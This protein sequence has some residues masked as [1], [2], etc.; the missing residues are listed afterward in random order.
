ML[1]PDQSGSRIRRRSHD[2]HGRHLQAGC[3]WRGNPGHS[4]ELEQ[5][6]HHIKPGGHGS[7][8]CVQ[9]VRSR[10]P[11]GH[12]ARTGDLGS[13]GPYKFTRRHD[14]SAPFACHAGVSQRPNRGQGCLRARRRPDRWPAAS[15]ARLAN[16]DERAGGRARHFAAVAVRCRL[17][18]LGAY[19]GRLRQGARAVRHFHW[20]IRRRPGKARPHGR[21]CLPCGSGAPLYLCRSCTRVQTGGRVGH[22]EAACHRAHAGIG[23][24]RHGRSRRQGC[25]RR[26]KQLSWQ[27]VPRIA[28]CDHRRGRQYSDT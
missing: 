14:G 27:F 12:K 5:A 25:D 22:H 4:S 1:R 18:V 20:E 10:R 9:I 15:G 23:E 19:V 26:A 6:L 28:C 17:R 7:R 2:G 11:I 21:Q 24:R 3:Q 13:V 16:A 8:A